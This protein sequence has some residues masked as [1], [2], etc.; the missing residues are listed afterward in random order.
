MEVVVAVNVPGNALHFPLTE[1]VP[2]KLYAVMQ[3]IVV[4]GKN[5]STVTFETLGDAESRPITP[6]LPCNDSGFL[7]GPAT[8]PWAKTGKG[9]RLGCSTG[10]GSGI[11]VWLVCEVRRK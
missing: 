1:T 6:E 7:L 5:G 3:G 11:A 4:G 9:E 8:L 10:P 2:K